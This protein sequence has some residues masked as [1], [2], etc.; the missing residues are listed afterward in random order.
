[1]SFFAP[2]STIEPSTLLAIALVMTLGGFVK[3][4]VGFALPMVA[5]SG[6][7]LFLTA[8]EAIAIILLPSAISNVWQTFRQGI[9]PAFQTFTRF[10]KLNFAMVALLVV[11]AQLVP[12]IPSDTLFVLLGIAVSLAAFSQLAGWRPRARDDAR[13]RGL[14]ETGIGLFAGTI[15][16]LTGVWGPPVLFYLIAL[17]TDKASQVR[18][19]GINFAIGWL[20]LSGAHLKSGVLNEVTAPLSLI[21]LLPV[22]AGMAMGIQLQERISPERFRK[23]TLIVLCAAGLNLLRRGLM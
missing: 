23:I 18:M 22:L 2:L 8:Q 14:I 7:G 12:R 4:A 6:L 5:L 20:A 11:A 16:G 19:L 3:G 9:S 1:M 21:M 17:G 10:W 15:G 13:N